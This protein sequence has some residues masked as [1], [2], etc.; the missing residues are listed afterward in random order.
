MKTIKD[1]SKLAWVECPII[2]K[3]VEKDRFCKSLRYKDYPAVVVA[4]SYEGIDIC[5][6]GESSEPKSSTYH[7]KIKSILENHLGAIGSYS[8]NCKN[9]IGNCAEPHAADKLERD[10]PKNPDC[11]KYV[12]GHGYRPRTREKVAMCVNCRKT[13]KK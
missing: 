11:K 4:A 3:R 6:I 2:C 12:F 1:L 10:I 7:S 5:K 13:F 8:N 9:K